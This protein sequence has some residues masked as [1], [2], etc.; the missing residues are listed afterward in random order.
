MSR[1]FVNEDRD[2]DLPRHHFVLPSRRSPSYDAAAAQLLLEA[3][4]EG[5]LYD[6]EQATGLKWGDSQYRP[7]VE[8]Y[9]AAEEAK[10]EAEQDRR[11][12]QVARRYLRAG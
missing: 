2:D 6:A 9:L 1:A 4:R 11:L 12:I 5:I 7:H 10:P 8:R 3:A